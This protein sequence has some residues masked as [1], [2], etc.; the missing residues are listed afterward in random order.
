[1]ARLFSCEPLESRQM[2]SSAPWSA[3]DKLIG[4]DKATANFP[5]VTGAGQTVAIIDEGTDYNHYALAG[6]IAFT[7]NFD[8]NSSD[9]MPY[10]NNSHGTGTAGQIAGNG[11]VVN[12]QWYQGVAP[13]V[14]IIALRAN[15]TAETKA[16]LDWIIAHRSQYN[17][18]AMNY[19]DF[20]GS[21]NEGAIVG[22]LQNL[23]NSGVFMAGAIGNYGPGPGY[24]HINHLIYQVGAVDLN[25]QL[26]SFTPRGSA[27]DV[28]A[29]GQNVDIAWY[30][31]GQHLDYTSSGTSWAGPQVTGTAALI[32]QINPGFSPSQILSII[33]DSAH[34]DYDSYSNRS[35][36]R[37]DVNAALSLAYQRSGKQ[38]PTSSYASSAPKTTT[39]TTTTS[40]SSAKPQSVSA[41]VVPNGPFGLNVITASSSELDLAWHDNST[42]ETAF[43]VQRS[44]SAAGKFRTVATVTA[45]KA[46]ARETGTRTF[47][48]KKLAAGTTYFYR[49]I[50]T[51]GVYTSSVASS[52]GMTS[53]KKKKH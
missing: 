3:Q 31:N 39:T 40:K 37:L 47:A 33:Q 27:V 4:L 41:G 22:E 32:K 51:N 21:V 12:G 29:P 30:S 2:L 25:D 5:S 38:A 42:N 48:D 1:M 50:A 35:Y 7:W 46:S 13:G 44:T 23:Y 17:I 24:A 28:V 8:T 16:A 14:K 9:V 45:T 20:T 49:V 10:D 43:I 19:L 52:S 18:T 53:S 34:W 15:G 36:A 6:K 26:T 11:R